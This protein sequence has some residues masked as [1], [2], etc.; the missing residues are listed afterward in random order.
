MG[1][2][3]KRSQQYKSPI[4]RIKVKHNELS[5]IK[6]VPGGLN[7]RK[8]LPYIPAKPLPCVSFCMYVVG[9]PG[10]GKTNVWA[11][12]FTNKEPKY[13][14]KFFDKTFLISGSRSTLPKKIIKGRNGVPPNQQFDNMRD[15]EIIKILGDLKEGENTNNCLIL[16]DCIMD[17]N[18]SRIL[19]WVFLNRRHI[20]H[21]EE[22]DNQHGNL[23]VFT[24]SQKYNEL[25]LLFRNA[26]SHF[27]IFKS[28]NQQEKDAIR[29]ELMN[30]LT[31]EQQDALFKAAWKEKHS[32]LYICNENDKEDGKYYI[33][34]D[35]VVFP[36]DDYDSSDDDSSSTTE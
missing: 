1:I 30:D 3:E 32:F 11:H 19:S 16:D 8:N 14:R 12:M 4:T 2:K 7:P 9:A 15:D 28:S 17:I 10:R 20:T 18:R 34:F 31:T 33:K 25:P 29:K 6:K 24:M 23:S 27:I 13:Y 5:N 36:R 35:E 22:E 21:N 26:C